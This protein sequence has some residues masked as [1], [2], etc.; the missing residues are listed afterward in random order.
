VLAHRVVVSFQA[1]AQGVRARDV[2]D[3]IVRAGGDAA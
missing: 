1:Q 2:I 3:E